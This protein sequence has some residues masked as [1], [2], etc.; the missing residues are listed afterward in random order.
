MRGSFS[1]V[2]LNYGEN[3]LLHMTEDVVVS[4]YDPRTH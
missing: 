4:C 3:E 1:F 2:T